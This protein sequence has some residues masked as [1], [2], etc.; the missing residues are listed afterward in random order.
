MVAWWSVDVAVR[1]LKAATMF[2]GV[3]TSVLLRVTPTQPIDPER[4]AGPVPEDIAAVLREAGQPD[5]AGLVHG[6]TG[7]VRL[8]F[9]LTGPDRVEVGLRL[10]AEFRRLGYDADVSFS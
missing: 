10:E 4:W 6:P 9:Q 1:Q 7:P 3:A 5:R 2:R 8:R